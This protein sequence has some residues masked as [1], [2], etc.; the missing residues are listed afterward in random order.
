MVVRA[1]GERMDLIRPGRGI[2]SR[3]VD[4]PFEELRREV[5]RL[6]APELPELPRFCGGAVGFLA[7]DVVRCFEPRIPATAHDD[8]GVPDLYLMFTDTVL[9]FDNVRQ[10]LK[11][12]ASVP[13]EEFDSTRTAYR[14][15]ERKIDQTIERAAAKPR[16]RA[17]P[18]GGP[19]QRHERGAD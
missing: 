9:V 13:I 2:E 15:G 8:L 16:S 6:R 5:K 10:T 18:C 19:A 3:K 4:N 1:R 14:S 7:Y 12:I 11:I 17:V